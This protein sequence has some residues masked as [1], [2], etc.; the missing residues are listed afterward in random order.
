MRGSGRYRNPSLDRIFKWVEDTIWA[1][2]ARSAIDD[3][4]LK[5]WLAFTESMLEALERARYS[6]EFMGLNDRDEKSQVEF[7][8]KWIVMQ[9]KLAQK[10]SSKRLEILAMEMQDYIYEPIEFPP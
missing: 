4:E 6:P 5:E 7:L 10:I 1:E 2:R 3:T 8:K 9:G